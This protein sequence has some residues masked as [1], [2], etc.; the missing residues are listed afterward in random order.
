MAHF[1]VGLMIGFLIYHALA[2]MIVITSVLVILFL[3]LLITRPWVS[4]WLNIA[5]IISQ[6]CILVVII[7]FLV[8]AILDHGSCIDCGD[9]EGRICWVVVLFLWLG[10]M[11]G[12]LLLLLAAMLGY[13]KKKIPE[14]VY[15]EDYH[16]STRKSVYNTVRNDEIYYEDNQIMRDNVIVSTN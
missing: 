7:I 2:Q 10:L 11:I 3:I 1:I 14:E 9:R 4:F 13:Y 8:Y 6:L 16:Y 5:D 12:L 15:V